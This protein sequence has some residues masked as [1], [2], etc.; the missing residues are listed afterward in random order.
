M[1]TGG[2][3]RVEAILSA[4]FWK[5]ATPLWDLWS[6]SDERMKR[7]LSS[8]SLFPALP[9]VAHAFAIA[10]TFRRKAF[11]W[12]LILVVGRYLWLLGALSAETSCAVT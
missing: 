11:R 5:N 1:V 7:V 8:S 10:T 12:P 4:V 2:K 9:C 3:G 6:G